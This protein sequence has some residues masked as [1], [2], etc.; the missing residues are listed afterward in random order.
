MIFLILAL[1]AIVGMLVANLKYEKLP[2]EYTEEEIKALR[3]YYGEGSENYMKFTPLP[4]P[5]K[6]GYYLRS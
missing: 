4:N 6:E 2:Y 5:K 1:L 3:E